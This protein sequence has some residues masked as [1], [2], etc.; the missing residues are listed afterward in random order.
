MTRESGQSTEAGTPENTAVSAVPPPTVR[1]QI[2]A[3]KKL[4]LAAFQNAVPAL[5]ELVIVNETSSPISDLTVQLVSEPPFVKPRKWDV[6]SVG[7]GE[8]YHLRDLD[9]HL[10]GALLSRLT[11]AESALLHFELRTRKQADEILARH[12]S[13]VELLAKS[14]GWHWSVARNGGGVCSAQRPGY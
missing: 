10:D 12:E 3:A 11:E 6:D 7:A 1:L 9:V 5:H 8:S 2:S 4:N 14:M 13:A